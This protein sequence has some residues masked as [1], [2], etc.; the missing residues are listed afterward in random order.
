MLLGCG[1]H[2]EPESRP[3]TEHSALPV[4]AQPHETGAPKVV[5]PQS[6]V[7]AVGEAA[8]GVVDSS[9]VPTGNPDPDEAGDDEA[10]EEI[11]VD[12][13]LKQV[14]SKSTSD[15]QA[16][17]ALRQAEKGKSPLAGQGCQCAGRNVI[18]HP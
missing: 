7:A 3:Q 14:R 2:A 1:K 13:L 15:E 11:S 18:R 6:T 8:E 4:A 10:G 9:P 16:L 17:V 5:E 12:A